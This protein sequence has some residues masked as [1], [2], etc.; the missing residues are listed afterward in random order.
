[1]RRMPSDKDFDALQ[2]Q[3]LQLEGQV[4]DLLLII[5]D[6]HSGLIGRIAT[7]EAV[8]GDESSGL[9][10]DVDDLQTDVSNLSGE[11][12]GLDGIP[13]R[14]TTL[15]GYFNANGVAKKATEALM[16]KYESG[17]IDS[18]IAFNPIAVGSQ[19]GAWEVS[20]GDITAHNLLSDNETRLSDVESNFDSSG[21]ALSA[22]KLYYNNTRFVEYDSQSDEW[23]I[24]GDINAA[25][26]D[27][28][29]SEMKSSTAVVEDADTSDPHNDGE[30]WN[31]SGTVKISAG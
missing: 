20:E 5:G 11:I 31:D 15:E 4:A 23:T 14:V 6:Q 9:V 25:G 18:Q 7:L 26:S 27:A 1:M 22:T 8:V 29:F 2:D 28:H 13:A 12:S 30:L 21:N 24:G 16:L 19:D 17:A 10:K 3:I